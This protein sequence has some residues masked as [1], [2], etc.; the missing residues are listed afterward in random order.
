MSK[1]LPKK[2]YSKEEQKGKGK[3]EDIKG[4]KDDPKG[5]KDDP[6][7]R[8]DEKGKS[9]TKLKDTKSKEKVLS[10]PNLPSESAS[11]QKSK[12]DVSGDEDSTN[13]FSPS[14]KQTDPLSPEASER[15]TQEV[16]P[17]SDELADDDKKVQ[18]HVPD[19]PKKPKKKSSEKDDVKISQSKGRDDHTQ[20]EADSKK[21]SKS[22]K[23]GKQDFGSKEDK[24][25]E[26]DRESKKKTRPSA[27]EK[28]QSSRASKETDNEKADKKGDDSRK[29]MSSAKKRDGKRDWCSQDYQE[30]EN[31]KFKSF[32]SR[33]RESDRDKM[34]RAQQ[35]E[36]TRDRCWDRQDG[37]RRKETWGP[38]TCNNEERQAHRNRQFCLPDQKESDLK[39]KSYYSTSPEMDYR[40]TQS[41]RKPKADSTRDTYCQY[42]DDDRDHYDVP[43][44]RH[45]V[46]GST[47]FNNDNRYMGR[48]PKCN[49][50]PSQLREEWWSK[51]S[52]P[53]GTTRKCQHM[54]ERTGYQNQRQCMPSRDNPS[55]RITQP[56]R[57]MCCLKHE[58]M[59]PSRRC[60]TRA[61]ESGPQSPLCQRFNSSPVSRK[62]ATPNVSPECQALRSFRQSYRAQ[63]KCSCFPQTLG[64]SACL[65]RRI[66]CPVSQ[67]N[68]YCCNDRGI[69]YLPVCSANTCEMEAGSSQKTPS[70]TNTSSWKRVQ[71]DS[72]L[73]SHRSLSAASRRN[74]YMDTATRFNDYSGSGCGRSTSQLALYSSSLRDTGSGFKSDKC[75]KTGCRYE[76][77]RSFSEARS[78][79]PYSSSSMSRFKINSNTPSKYSPVFAA[80]MSNPY[81]TNSISYNSKLLSS[82]D[83]R[84]ATLSCSCDY[85]G[86]TSECGA[87]NRSLTDRDMSSRMGSNSEL[88]CTSY[89]GLSGSCM[90]LPK[91]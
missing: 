68:D 42:R 63:G 71:Q 5:K 14:P 54:T 76:P 19:E 56:A 23:P 66:T 89:Q 52:E 28:Q 49:T 41:Y 61:Q 87:T 91:E 39:K 33:D 81:Q 38:C 51:R 85:R 45:Y 47:S 65:P 82:R 9:D 70:Y 10:S 79:T 16:E 37:V 20:E 58:D 50:S 57:Q 26:T 84:S 46:H 12:L 80:S 35:Y 67:C 88:K 21:P 36:Q 78:Q 30:N 7:G 4:K 60:C 90:N 6:K 17:T 77:R 25:C 73:P 48:A 74:H 3:K 18:E 64:S 29:E 32:K 22:D 69:T 24:A 59:S 11:K 40:Q 2:T 72:T 31:K 83:N 86:S 13:E 53:T 27:D 75:M 44:S 43:K 34:M 15:Y 1:P 62:R 55:M 8:K